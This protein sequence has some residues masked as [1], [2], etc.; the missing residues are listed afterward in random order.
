M[1]KALLLLA[2]IACATVTNRA[3]AQ[4][5][6]LKT[7]AVGWAT[8][9]INAAWEVG[10]SKKSTLEIGAQWNPWTFSNNKKVKHL[11]LQPEWRHW[12]CQRFSRGFF[13]VHALGGIFNMGGVKTPFNMLPEI[14]HNRLQ[15]W[16][17]GVGVSYGWDW[18]LAPHWN[19]EAT[20]GVGYVYY[21]Y[22]KFDC[23]RCG[24][25]IGKGHKNYFGPT[26]LGLSLSYLF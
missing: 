4:S 12:M 24:D 2:L 17:A 20:A 23:A 15:G 8:T 19:L 16:F 22:E 18:V 9:S 10:L 7:N 6:A 5:Q 1:R 21:K 26:K 14:R 25:Q 11:M 13:G 3:Q